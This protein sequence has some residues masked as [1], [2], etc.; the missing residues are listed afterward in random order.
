MPLERHITGISRHDNT[1]ESRP[2]TPESHQKQTLP[3]N[4]PHALQNPQLHPHNRRPSHRRQRRTT[5]PTRRR[6]NPRFRN[7]RHRTSPRNTRTR[8][9]KSDALRLPR[10]KQSYPEWSIAT[11]I[12]TD[13]VTVETDKTSPLWMTKILTIQAARKRPTQSLF[14]RNDHPRKRPQ[15]H[16]HVPPPRCNQPRPRNRATHDSMR[17]TSFNHRRSHGVFSAE[18]SPESTNVVHSLGS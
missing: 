8:R 7:N 5:A 3:Y 2:Y 15:E 10:R 18:K 6:P 12:T 4:P 17:T 14:G 9:R 11:P 13:S 16:D 1:S